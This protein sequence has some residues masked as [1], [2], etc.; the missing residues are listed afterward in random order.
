MIGYNSRENNKLKIK[1][2]KSKKIRRGDKIFDSLLGKGKYFSSF[3][4]FFFQ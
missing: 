2:G 4:E 1:K 3:S